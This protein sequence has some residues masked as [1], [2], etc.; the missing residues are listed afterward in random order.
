MRKSFILNF[1]IL[2]ENLSY[3]L[4]YVPGQKLAVWDGHMGSFTLYKDD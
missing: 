4:R 3:I 2:I 1:I